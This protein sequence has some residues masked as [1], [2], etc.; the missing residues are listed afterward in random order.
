MAT[1]HKEKPVQW[2][3]LNTEDKQLTKVILFSEIPV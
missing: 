3:I 2:H 1:Q